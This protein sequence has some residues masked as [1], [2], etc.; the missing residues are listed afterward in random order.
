MTE[1]EF[2]KKRFKPFSLIDYK[3]QDYEN[4]DGQKGVEWD[5]IL[6]AI[7]F[8]ERLLKIVPIP[9]D[10]YEEKEVWVRCENCEISRPKPKK[11]L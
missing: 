3:N 11:L 7:D 10:F 9:N 8:E 1:Q 2:L 4:I 5:G 6:L